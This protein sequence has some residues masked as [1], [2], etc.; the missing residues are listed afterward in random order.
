MIIQ[1]A[2]DVLGVR[3]ETA[4][5]AQLIASQLR[6]NPEWTEVVAGLDSVCVHFDP[7]R[8]DV[9]DAEVALKSTLAA[10]IDTASEPPTPE[11]EIPVHYGAEAGPDLAQVCEQLDLTQAEFVRRHSEVT[12]TADM[13]GFTPGFAYLSGLDKG[14]S[15]ARLS[16]PR[17]RVPAGSIGISGAYC[18]LYALAGPGGWPIVGQ[19]DLALFDATRQKPFRIHPGHSVRF[20]PR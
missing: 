12:Y 19:T 18:G 4:A 2:E 6:N 11:L 13:I 17:V 16:R 15:V 5:R 20:V 10:A 1:I 3:V 8:L 14:L 9:M 7:A